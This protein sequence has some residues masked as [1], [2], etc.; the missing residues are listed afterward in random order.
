MKILENPAYKI[1]DRLA[2]ENVYIIS[3]TAKLDQTMA[4]LIKML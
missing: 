1:L 4:K 3:P 2:P